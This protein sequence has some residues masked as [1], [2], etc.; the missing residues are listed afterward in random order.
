MEL[1]LKHLPLALKL[2]PLRLQSVLQATCVV[3]LASAISLSALVAASPAQAQEDGLTT[4][5]VEGVTID[6]SEQRVL[7]TTHGGQWL[8][9]DGWQLNRRG[10][11]LLRLFDEA[12]K[13]GLTPS[14]Y[15]PDRIR[16][17]IRNATRD[18]LGDTEMLMTEM[19]IR[20]LEDLR[21]GRPVPLVMEEH[22]LRI[23]PESDFDP[24]AVLRRGMVNGDL[25]RT[26]R[27][28]APQSD[29]YQALRMELGEMI[30]QRDR[31]DHEFIPGGRVMREGREDPRVPALRRR[32]NA[33]GYA[34]G[35]DEDTDTFFTA[36]MA[37]AVRDFQRDNGLSA[38]GAVGPRTLAALN[39]SVDDHIRTL[40]ANMERYRWMQ[41]DRTGKRVEMNIPE[42]MLTAYDEYGTPELEMRVIVGKPS[43]PTPLHSS[44]LNRVDFFPE[45]GAPP[46]IV[47]EDILPRVQRDVGYL[48]KY[49]YKVVEWRGGQPNEL[50]PYS[51]DWSQYTGEERHL[52]FSF[53]RSSGPGNPL[54]SVRFMVENDI[55]IYL[56]DTSS[57]GKFKRKRRFLSSGCVRVQDPQGFANYILQGNQEWDSSRIDEQFRRA[58][59]SG[60]RTEYVGLRQKVP[61]H[62]MYFTAV[63]DETGRI[64]YLDDVYGWDRIIADSLIGPVG[65]QARL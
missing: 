28:A 5:K 65:R 62:L 37:A 6:P 43:R 30:H 50:D 42:T 29:I 3:A 21:L 9:F 36:D 56:H 58:R 22:V 12:E 34:A 33:D 31:E 59:E 49:N 7:Y 4:V 48:S 51:I 23:G 26:M 44:V 20:Y 25:A 45:W 39:K 53:R 41:Y 64:K 40:V 60:L 14:R 32:L 17:R 24:I 10:G 52:P 27:R 47:K 63:L 61:V 18:N 11:E 35:W 1:R 2:R 8:W 15:M 57:P 46:T 55:Y 54:G 16:A 38:D 19:A 13:E